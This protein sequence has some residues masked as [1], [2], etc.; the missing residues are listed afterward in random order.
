M[1]SNAELKRMAWNR[2]WSGGWFWRLFGGGALLWLSGRAV[3]AVV[4]TVYTVL[5]MQ[6]W[7]DYF[8]AVKMNRADLTTPVPQLNRAYVSQLTTATGLE[9]FFGYLVA[10]IIAYG[11]AV[12]LLKCLRN[13]ERDW[14]VE[15]FAGFKF[16]LAL[17]WLMIRYVLVFIGWTLLAILPAGLIA[18]V[19]ASAATGSGAVPGSVIALVSFVLVCLAAAALSV[20]F[21]RYRFLFLVKA[22]NPELP[23]GECMRICR[24]LTDGH[25][26]RSFKLD[27][28]YWLPI[29]LALLPIAAAAGFATA[30]VMSPSGFVKAVLVMAAVLGFLAAMAASIVV[31]QYISVGQGFLYL[32]LKDAGAAQ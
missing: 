7:S 4:G 28:S 5:G 11:G 3:V 27:C 9:M 8:I 19:C 25:K 26:L 12:I 29:L 6:S 30:G 13:D 20:P 2:L 15:A 16:P 14:L 24:A 1:K 21:Y 31:G 32:E 18:G 10:G 17:L 23:A 22:E